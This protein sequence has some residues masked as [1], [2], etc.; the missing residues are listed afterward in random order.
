MT[1][2]Q[3]DQLA[4]F[5][6][7]EYEVTIE[8]TDCGEAGPCYLARHPDLRGCMSHGATPEEARANLDDARA[9]YLSTMIENGV[10]PPLPVERAATAVGSAPAGR[11]G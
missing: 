1:D 7:L 4:R 6:A 5:L 8:Q 11:A 2:P 10:T 3:A 9:L